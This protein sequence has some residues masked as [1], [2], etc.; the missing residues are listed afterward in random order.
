MGGLRAVGNRSERDQKGAVGME[1]VQG[2]M[3]ELG[4]ILCAVWKPSKMEIFWNYKG[5]PSQEP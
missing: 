3:L 4:V 5:D 1:E 2:G